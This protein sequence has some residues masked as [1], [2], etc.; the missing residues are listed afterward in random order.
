MSLH[1]GVFMLWLCR[2]AC[3]LVE[4]ILRSGDPGGLK[5]EEP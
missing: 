5:E 3:K 2:T 1:K 4:M